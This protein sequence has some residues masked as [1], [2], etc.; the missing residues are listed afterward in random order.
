MVPL[1]AAGG[2]WRFN[3]RGECSMSEI[4]RISVSNGKKSASVHELAGAG[5]TG[6]RTDPNGRDRRHDWDLLERLEAENLELR[7][8]AVQLALQIQTLRLRK[9]DASGRASCGS[10]G[11]SSITSRRRPNR[12]S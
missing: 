5:G 11:V 12:S 7:N 6:P 8:R 9:P 10:G 2:T 1:H 3:P 4:A